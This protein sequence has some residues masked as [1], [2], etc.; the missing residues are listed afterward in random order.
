VVDGGRGGND[1]VSTSEWLRIVDKRL[2]PLPENRYGEV[3]VDTRRRLGAFLRDPTIALHGGAVRRH[4]S[5][6]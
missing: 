1:D 2:V 4:R 3:P 6:A 5:V